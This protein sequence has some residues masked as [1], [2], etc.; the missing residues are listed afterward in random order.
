MSEQPSSKLM[1]FAAKIRE[2][3]KV[4]SDLVL[5]DTIA[6]L[7]HEVADEVVKLKATNAWM[8]SELLARGLRAD[9][10]WTAS[11]I[12]ESS[13]GGNATAVRSAVSAS[14]HGKAAVSDGVPISPEAGARLSARPDAECLKAAPSL[15]DKNAVVLY[16]ENAADRDELVALIHEAKPGMRAVNL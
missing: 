12:A 10:P 13:A 5:L 6:A 7:S 4:R 1:A 3:S 15:K 2:A 11:D 8:R 9:P 16:F 14:S